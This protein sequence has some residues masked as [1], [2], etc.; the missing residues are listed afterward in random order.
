MS[1]YTW[2][3]VWK[4]F[5]FVGLYPHLHLC[6]AKPWDGW[7]SAPCLNTQTLFHPCTCIVHLPAHCIV[8]L[9][10]DCRYRLK[11]NSEMYD[12]LVVWKPCHN[13]LWILGVLSTVFRR[14]CQCPPSLYFSL[15]VAMYCTSFFIHNVYL[16]YLVPSMSFSFS[17]TFSSLI[18]VN[19]YKVPAARPFNN[20][21]TLFEDYVE[22]YTV[23]WVKK[24][25][26]R[27]YWLRHNSC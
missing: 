25:H 26:I 2:L 22:L 5:S 27:D 8:H 11:L 20:S 6:S 21:L 4:V 10:C 13:V 23:K 14:I 17:L 12:F 7:L 16:I 1:Y 24:A 9:T 19:S 15:R 3:G 18:E